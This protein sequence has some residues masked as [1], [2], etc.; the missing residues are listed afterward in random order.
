M[1]S[2]RHCPELASY[3]RHVMPPASAPAS[4]LRLAGGDVALLPPDV[5]M[6]LERLRGQVGPFL[7]PA[8]APS[9]NQPTLRAATQM[10]SNAGVGT[11]S[12]GLRCNGGCSF[13]SGGVMQVQRA[14]SGQQ[15]SP[16]SPCM[17]HSNHAPNLIYTFSKHTLALLRRL[18]VCCSRH[19]AGARCSVVSIHTEH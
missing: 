19:A 16:C 17:P 4:C 2:V 1:W 13:P 6:E 11:P 18:S 15:L 10:C 12:I 14:L 3:A 8:L 7:L 5:R 9:L